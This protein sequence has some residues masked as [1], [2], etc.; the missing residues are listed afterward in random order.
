MILNQENNEKF[1]E[2][3]QKIDINKGKIGKKN[4]SE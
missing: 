1:I 4:I 3:K 2:K